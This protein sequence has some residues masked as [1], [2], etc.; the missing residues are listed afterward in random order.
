MHT[1]RI[2]TG[3]AVATVATA[4]AAGPA[5]ALQ[6]NCSST[7]RMCMHYNSSANG[8]NAEFGSDYNVPSFNPSRTTDDIYFKAGSQGSAGAGQWVWNGAASVVNPNLTVRVGVFVDSDYN[9][10]VD[11]ANP[12][13]TKNLVN[14]KNNDASM[15]WGY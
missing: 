7:A 2:L 13:Q 14:T 3:L 12:G 15:G 5:S 8:L 10:L 11:I 4:F 1:R 9:G 6:R